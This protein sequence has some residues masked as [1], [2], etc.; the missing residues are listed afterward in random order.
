MERRLS[1][2]LIR[3][4]KAFISL[5]VTCKIPKFASMLRSCNYN[6]FKDEIA[7]NT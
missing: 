7:R 3:L 4:L 1:K 2:F 5:A 6:I